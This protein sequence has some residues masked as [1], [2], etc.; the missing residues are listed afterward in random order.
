MRKIKIIIAVFFIFFLAFNIY[1][2]FVL[3]D[4]E[5]AYG[6]GGKNAPTIRKYIIEG[7]GY[8]LKSHSDFLLFLNKI[9]LSELNG[10]DYIELQNIIKRVIENLENAKAAYENLIS[11]AKET[12]YNESVI[13][14]LK[15]SGSI[16]R[17]NARKCK[18]PPNKKSFY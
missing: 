10:I 15:N 4:G 18:L 17:Y 2:Y 12:P 3:N 7:A 6:G 14:K 1:G 8:F 9:E 13:E 11:I 5:S 16:W